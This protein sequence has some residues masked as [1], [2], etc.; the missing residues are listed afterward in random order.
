MRNL[1][2]LAALTPGL[3]LAQMSPM[4]VLL[5]PN[6][7]E[8]SDA[9][10]RLA[11]GF[12]Q[13]NP[14]VALARTELAPLGVKFAP[15]GTR[16]APPSV[17]TTAEMVLAPQPAQSQRADDGKGYLA[18]GAEYKLR[19]PLRLLTS[20]VQIIQVGQAAYY[21]EAPAT[22]SIALRFKQSA[23]DAVRELV[24]SGTGDASRNEFFEVDAQHAGA[25]GLPART[26][27]A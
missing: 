17:A 21:A 24:D 18:V 16:F 10:L 15:P 5:A 25:R 11:S 9:Q 22:V 6:G 12:L 2:V 26:A 4:N 8:A 20:P 14:Q 7:P 19:S 23:A 13:C 3:V 1:L 27:S